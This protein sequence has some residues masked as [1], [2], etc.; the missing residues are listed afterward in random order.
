MKTLAISIVAICLATNAAAFDDAQIKAHCGAKWS[1]DFAMQKFCI[2]N[3]REAGAQVDAI[4]GSSQSPEQSAATN[5]CLTKWPGDYEMQNFCIG[6][7]HG[8]IVTT[9]DETFGLPEDVLSQ[10]RSRC[11]SKWGSDFEMI[12]YCAKQQAEGWKAIQD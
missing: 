11:R 2:D 5:H 4:L 10:V 6:N 12:V 7:Q 9:Q 3:Q 1:D 8:A